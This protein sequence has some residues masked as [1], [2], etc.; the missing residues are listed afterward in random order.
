[1]FHSGRNLV[2]A[3]F[4]SFET[5]TIAY[6]PEANGKI[7]RGHSPIVKALAKACDG[8]VKNWPQMLPYALWVDRTTHSSVTGYMPI[9]LMTGET[10]VMPTEPQ[11]GH[12]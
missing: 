4:D 1:M 11:L 7:E 8:R 5:L 12:G 2:V 9:E 10:M 3:E 6:N